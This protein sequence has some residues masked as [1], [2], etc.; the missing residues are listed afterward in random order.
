M[1]GGKQD[2]DGLFQF[3]LFDKDFFIEIFGGWVKIVVVGCVCFG[4]IFMGVIVVEI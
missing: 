3:G 2:D 1:I 4:G